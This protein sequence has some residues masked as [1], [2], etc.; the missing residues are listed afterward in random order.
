MFISTPV[1]VGAAILYVVNLVVLVYRRRLPR[2]NEFDN[3]GNAGVLDD[4]RLAAELKE[5]KIKTAAEL[6]EKKRK[7]DANKKEK[8]YDYAKDCVRRFS[9]MRS[10][11]PE[12]QFAYHMKEALR[13]YDIIKQDKD[14]D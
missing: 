11:D 2:S 6:E 3:F 13:Y 8:F 5:S 9:S 1:A 14:N 10:S 12:W 7:T 4:I